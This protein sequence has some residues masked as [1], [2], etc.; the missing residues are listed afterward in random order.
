[1]GIAQFRKKKLN[2]ALKSFTEVTR[3]DPSIG[4]AHFFIGRV[5]LAQD[6]FYEGAA[7][8]AMAGNLMKGDPDPHLFMAV[9]YMGLNQRQEAL[10][11]VNHALAINPGYADALELRAKIMS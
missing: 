11:A 6:R 1:M 2:D 4:L 3:L 8:F 5:Y 9:C 7:A 10:N